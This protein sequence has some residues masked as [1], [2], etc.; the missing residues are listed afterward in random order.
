MG[1]V[2]QDGRYSFDQLAI[3]LE[4]SPQVP[5][6][7][8]PTIS[9]V[10]KRGSANLALHILLPIPHRKLECHLVGIIPNG[11]SSRQRHEP[12]SFPTVR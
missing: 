11:L 9:Q 5:R 7:A 10:T 8:S 12:A 3:G 2:E 6:R 4:F 1:L